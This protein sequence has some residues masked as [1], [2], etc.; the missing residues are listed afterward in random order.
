LDAELSA[1]KAAAA[2]KAA[3]M[4]QSG[5]TLSRSFGFSSRTASQAVLDAAA[6]VAAPGG[7]A[8]A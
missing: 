8:A 5:R 6:G 7:S 3:G 4:T 1:V 2:A